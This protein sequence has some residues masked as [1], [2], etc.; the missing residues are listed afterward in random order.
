MATREQVLAPANAV[1][2]A[3]LAMSVYG[4]T[5]IDELSGVLWFGAGRVADVI[6]GP[7]ARYT[8]TASPFGAKFDAAA[9][10]IAVAFGCYF[11]WVEEVAPQP[12]IAT[13]VG[14]NLLNA[15][16]NVY[17]EYAGAEPET[18]DAGKTTMAAFM[19]SMGS[20]ALSN[21]LESTFFEGVAVGSFFAGLPY[22]AKSSGRYAKH[23][24]QERQ[25]S[26]EPKQNH[27]RPKR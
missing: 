21:A 4:A 26:S 25:H 12:V 10:K 1:T 14:V 5:N 24:W 20:F 18:D 27:K 3:G 6:D 2:A 11:A 9:D 16:A 13:I 7:V 17:L 8:D 22:A 19:A 15:A 23:A